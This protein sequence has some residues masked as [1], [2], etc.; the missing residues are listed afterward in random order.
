MD[1]QSGILHAS[2]EKD[3]KTAFSYFFEV[4]RSSFLTWVPLYYFRLLN[5]IITSG[6]AF[7]QYDSVEDPMAIKALK[8]MLLSKVSFL[9]PY[10]LRGIVSR[11]LFCILPGDV[12]LAGWGD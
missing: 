3:F 9:A 4:S 6:Q 11:D 2:E 1:L 12:E 7:E 5:G 10:Q 8:Y